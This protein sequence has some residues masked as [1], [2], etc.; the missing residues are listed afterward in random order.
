MQYDDLNNTKI[1]FVLFN[2]VFKH[3]YN[4]IYNN[5]YYYNIIYN[6][7]VKHLHLFSLNYK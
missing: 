7:I 4:L 1:L 6:N 2:S 5:N 3:I